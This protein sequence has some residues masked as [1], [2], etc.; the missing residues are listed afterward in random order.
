VPVIF[1][2]LLAVVS[3]VLAFHLGAE[4]AWGRE[5]GEG[6]PPEGRPPPP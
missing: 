4:A 3:I 5:A 6:G 2:P 1:D